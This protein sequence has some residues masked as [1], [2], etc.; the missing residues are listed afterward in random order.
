[1]GTVEREEKDR[2]DSYSCFARK[3]K[4]GSLPCLRGLAATEEMPLALLSPRA[5]AP[6]SAPKEGSDHCHNEGEVE[7]HIRERRNRFRVLLDVGCHV[8]GAREESPGS[9]GR[10]IPRNTYV[11]QVLPYVQKICKFTGFFV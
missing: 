2:M 6:T 9:V 4:A 7:K 10:S 11:M 8:M 5:P 1:M 3:F